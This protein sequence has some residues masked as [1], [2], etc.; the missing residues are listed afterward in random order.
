VSGCS[1]VSNRHLTSA[2][3][4]KR[5]FELINIVADDRYGVVS[6]LQARS[7][8]EDKTQLEIYLDDVKDAV[9]IGLDKGSSDP[10]H[11]IA[12]EEQ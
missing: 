3:S 7:S 5:I 11:G 8:S 12:K 2:R 6:E 10:F 9:V 1:D 4:H